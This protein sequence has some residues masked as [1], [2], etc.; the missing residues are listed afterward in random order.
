[1]SKWYDYWAF[2]QYGWAKNKEWFSTQ[3]R[4][5]ALAHIEVYYMIPE[6]ILTTFHRDVMKKVTDA[7][8]ES[9]QVRG[10]V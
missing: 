9:F 2:R 3:K 4:S 1:M 8:W 6:T 5:D 7:E 10:I